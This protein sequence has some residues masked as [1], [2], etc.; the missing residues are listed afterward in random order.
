MASTKPDPAPL[1][2]FKAS[3]RRSIWEESLKCELSQLEINVVADI[4]S[5]DATEKANKPVEATKSTPDL[6]EDILKSVTTCSSAAAR[7]EKK[8]DTMVAKEGDAD[9]KLSS[10]DAMVETLS[11]K[12]Q[13]LYQV[14]KQLEQPI[15]FRVP[16]GVSGLYNC[17]L[18]MKEGRQ[19]LFESDVSAF[20]ERVLVHKSRME[21]LDMLLYHKQEEI[22]LLDEQKTLLIHDREEKQSIC[23]QL[24]NQHNTLAARQALL[25]GENVEKSVK[26][27]SLQEQLE[28]I[29]A[30]VEE[31]GAEMQEFH[32][33]LN[34]VDEQKLEK[35]DQ[36][37]ALDSQFH[38]ASESVVEK[39]QHLLKISSD[40][41][42]CLEKIR[43]ESTL[44]NE[45]LSQQIAR[46]SAEMLMY[47]NAHQ[48][49][50][51][52]SSIL[53]GRRSLAEQQAASAE[54]DERSRQDSAII[55]AVKASLGAVEEA[56]PQ[57]T[58][59][60]ETMRGELRKLKKEVDYA[61]A[62]LRSTSERFK[63][64]EVQLSE[65]EGELK[66]E[67]PRVLVE[68]RKQLAA[69]VTA[70]EQR[71]FRAAKLAHELE[72][73]MMAMRNQENS[74]DKSSMRRDKQPAQLPKSATKRQAEKYESPLKKRAVVPQK[75]TPVKFSQFLD[76]TLTTM[77][78]DTDP[79]DIFE[80]APSK[81]SKPH[82]QPKATNVVVPKKL[83]RNRSINCRPTA[84]TIVPPKP[85]RFN[86]ES[87][88]A[89][90]DA[91][92]LGGAD[93]EAGMILNQRFMESMRHRR[94]LADISFDI[95]DAITS[96]PIATRKTV[97]KEPPKASKG[98]KPKTTRA[99]PS[100]RAW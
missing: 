30:D 73:E 15:T 67:E 2:A 21:E 47:T 49:A 69:M 54:L 36:F 83:E 82:I 76:E 31:F 42:D 57:S 32:V 96:T 52:W 13:E 92:D 3:L 24:E 86:S 78:P 89:G 19:R 94:D 59:E 97:A 14:S 99:T 27:V 18:A 74:R 48:R 7:S 38:D 93:S 68:K 77:D 6:V 11:R 28:A 8:L 26:T 55:S 60:L 4:A 88:V 17:A 56:D 5:R 12:V 65:I 39:N 90:H 95:A 75:Y 16:A 20:R 100:R 85:R 44:L 81:K 41:A 63:G 79:E 29:D 33:Q 62:E 25:K 40:L 22:N 72:E 1:F 46:H 34:A 80:P 51:L 64:L 98:Q 50:A 71:K 35:A 53:E 45:K 70:N 87:T 58:Y 91:E 37:E 61:Q 84:Q 66:A 9:K 23:E 10:T 43:A